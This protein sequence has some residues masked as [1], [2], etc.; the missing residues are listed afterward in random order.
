[1]PRA[2]SGHVKRQ[3]FTEPTFSVS[4]DLIGGILQMED[5]PGRATPDLSRLCSESRAD[6]VF[7]RTRLAVSDQISAPS[8]PGTRDPGLILASR[9]DRPDVLNGAALNR[10]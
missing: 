2:G 7:P 8:A 10:I 9:R 4:G 3:S 6:P 1:M 5:A